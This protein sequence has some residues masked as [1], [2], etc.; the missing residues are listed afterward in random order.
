MKER[1]TKVLKKKS[2]TKKAEQTLAAAKKQQKAK[3]LYSRESQAQLTLQAMAHVDD[4]P[5]KGFDSILTGFDQVQFVDFS[6]DYKKCLK[7]ARENLEKNEKLSLLE[8][9]EMQWINDLK[10]IRGKPLSQKLIQLKVNQGPFD[11]STHLF[12]CFEFAVGTHS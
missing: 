3:T 5:K 9:Q 12:S 11:P 10:E 2:K 8:K 1:G 6:R 7:M 4:D